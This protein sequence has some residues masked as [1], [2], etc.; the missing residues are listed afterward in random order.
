MALVEYNRQDN[1]GHITLNRPEKLNAI[2][3]EMSLAL[4]DALYAFYDD[5]TAMV[6]IISGNGKAFSSGADVKQRQLR[7]QAELKKLGGPS[8]REGNIRHPFFKPP[9]AKPII[10]AMHGYVYGVALRIALY[11]DLT[12]ASRGTKFQVTEVARGID[13]IPFWMMLTQRGAGVFADDVCFTG[14]TWLAEEAYESKLLSRLAQPGEHLAAAEILALEILNNPPLAV[15]AM[16]EAR[17]SALEEIDAKA[18]AMR[19]RSLH[20]SEDFRESAL[21]FVE[22]R[23][24]VY[25]GR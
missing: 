1:I 7:P 14:R 6:G 15:R 12:V 25:R 19:P 20:L 18:Y 13:A 24:P 9:Q 23:K 22:K 17:R 11:C 5:E 3:D 4:C 8:A 10:A 21:A 2:S 16:V